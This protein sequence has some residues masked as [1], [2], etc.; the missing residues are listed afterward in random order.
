MLIIVG[1]E[2]EG[3]YK[4][5]KA[6]QEAN[7]KDRVIFERRGSERHHAGRF[8][9]KVERRRSDRRRPLSDA[10]CALMKVLGFTVLHRELRVISGS[11]APRKPLAR[12]TLARATKRSRE[13]SAS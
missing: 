9:P 1:R 8:R 2:Y 3:L 11:R 7:G 6:R 10:E 4:G 12:R 5:L 13:K